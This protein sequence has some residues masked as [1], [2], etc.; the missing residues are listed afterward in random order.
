MHAKKKLCFLAFLLFLSAFM[1]TMG[2]AVCA[3]E[4]ENE[5]LE[6]RK[7]ESFHTSSLPLPRFASL[8]KEKTFVRSGPGDQYPV[9]WV[10]ERKYLPVE[11]VLEYDNWRKVRDYEGDEGWVFQGML[12]GKR[13][14][15]VTGKDNVPVYESRYDMG[16]KESRLVA[17]LEPF[18]LA[19]L[20]SCEG[21]WCHIDGIGFSGWVK[22]KSIWGVYESENFD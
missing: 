19:Q 9:K 17:Y 21:P 11:I 8:E 2:H 5:I 6:Q 1:L 14:A 3:Q 16:G 22:R 10:I 12:T 7:E 4:P 13:M 18:V 20:K 15:I